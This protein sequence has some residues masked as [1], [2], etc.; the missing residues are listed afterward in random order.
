MEAV[1]RRAAREEPEEAG[2]KRAADK[3]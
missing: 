1:V 3:R 2:L